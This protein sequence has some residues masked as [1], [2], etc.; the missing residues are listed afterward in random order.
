[1]PAKHLVCVASGEGGASAHAKKRTT[2]T[3]T[4]AAAAATA[5]DAHAAGS[6]AETEKGAAAAASSDADTA[7][8][9]DITTRSPSEKKR[10]RPRGSKSKKTSS[11]KKICVAGS[12]IDLT[13]VPPQP[14][15]LKNN[16]SRTVYRDIA[17]LLPR[18]ALLAKRAITNNHPG[19][20]RLNNIILSS[21]HAFSI[22]PK[23]E[24]KKKTDFFNRIVRKVEEGG[25]R[26]LVPD[27]S[28]Y[29][30]AS[31]SAAK[32]AVKQRLQRPAKREFRFVSDAALAGI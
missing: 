4:V 24:R 3:V 19:N 13:G 12:Y 23:N 1:M 16:L 14:L 26:F 28:G 18:D 22:I 30:L 15:I 5:T 11:V 8:P 32:K 9:N 20:I 17:V 25:T 7:R 27:G 29:A 10:G 6:T 31:P 21:Q 2:H